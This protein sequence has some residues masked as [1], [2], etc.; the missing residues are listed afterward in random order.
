MNTGFSLI[1]IHQ[2]RCPPCLSRRRVVLPAERPSRSGA[3]WCESFV[4]PRPQ[5]AK[6]WPPSL[7]A[8]VPCLPLC[9]SQYDGSEVGS[10]PWSLGV[11]FQ[12]EKRG[13][14]RLGELPTAR[15]FKFSTTAV[16]RDVLK[17]RLHNH[18]VFLVSVFPPSV[19][20]AK[21]T[22]TQ[23]NIAGNWTGLSGG[24]AMSL[25]FRHLGMR[26]RCVAVEF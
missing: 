6:Y 8:R 17:F 26:G 25:V 23:T 7:L 9:L 22:A 3:P 20:H 18:G 21:E 13:K 1:V 24:I 14:W 10:L 12:L 4:T 2:T 19:Q 11:F 15:N 5:P 16:G